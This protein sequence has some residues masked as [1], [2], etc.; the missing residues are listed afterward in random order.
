M[1]DNTTNLMEQFSRAVMLLHRYMHHRMRDQRFGDPHRGQGRV[2]SLLKMQPEI[3]QKDLSYLLDM[4]NQSLGE[5]LTKLERSGYITRTPSE[6]D[7]RVVNIKLTEAGAEAANQTEQSQQDSSKIFDCLNE[8]EQ[9]K[10][11]EYM[12]RLITELE[13]QTGFEENEFEGP[14]ERRG[15]FQGRMRDGRPPFGRGGFPP[16]GGFG[17]DRDWY[18]RPGEEGSD[19]ESG[20]PGGE[21][22]S[23]K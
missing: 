9:Q 23:G 7:R 15:G 16:H 2:L 20:G 3:S 6:T 5:L 8:E 21:N 14:W 17:F 22:G 1:S 18:A 4:R 10:L 11:G 12:D 19:T 13:K